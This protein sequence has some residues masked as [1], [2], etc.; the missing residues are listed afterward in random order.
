MNIYFLTS[1]Y[2]Y[3][4][5]KT[6]NKQF[7]YTPTVEKNVSNDSYLIS[8][9]TC[10]PLNIYRKQ[11]VSS[12]VSLSTTTCNTNCSSEKIIGLPLKML[13]KKNN[14]QAKSCCTDTQ[15]PVG[16]KQ[17]N[18][19]SFSGNAKLRSA[20]QPKNGSY[21]T[22]FYTYLR[23]RGNTFY[24]KDKFRNIPNTDYSNPINSSYY[25]T[26]V[27]VPSCPQP[28]IK[29][30][31]KPNNKNFGVQGAVSSDTRIQRLK[32]N[33]IQK[34][35]LS[36]SK[37]PFNTVLYYSLDPVFF[38]KNKV[39]TCVVPTTSIHTPVYQASLFAPG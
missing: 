28:Y 16:S 17:G 5:P 25:E 36:F 10:R 19:M 3:F 1:K 9:P 24:T 6:S 34:N 30:T 32:Y 23:S 20:V 29:T 22:D 31:Y 33:T 8:Y 13:Y 35:N 14:G 18:V 7:S 27:G 2:M 4:I 38:E 21:Y 39:N 15:G 26:H 12:V 11:G 37:P